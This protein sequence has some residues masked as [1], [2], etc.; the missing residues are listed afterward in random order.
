MYSD[1]RVTKRSL[2]PTDTLVMT[3]AGLN[4]SGN[5]ND[6][7]N[8]PCGI[9]VDTNLDLYVA[10]GNNSRIQLFQTGQTSGITVAGASAPQTILL[11]YPTGVALDA[12]GYLFIVDS[13]STRV[14][15]SSANGFRCRTW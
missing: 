15:G 9:F 7:L 1:H 14:I 6:E 11:S 13:S 4:H 3:A 8:E 2:S 12:N 10:D 5:G